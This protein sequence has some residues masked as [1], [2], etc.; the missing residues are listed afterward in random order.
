MPS[1]LFEAPSMG[2][3]QPPRLPDDLQTAPERDADREI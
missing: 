2:W 3:H 1:E